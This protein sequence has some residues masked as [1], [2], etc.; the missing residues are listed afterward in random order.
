MRR[1]RG[2]GGRFLNTKKLDQND[3]NPTSEKGSV[4]GVTLSTQSA[5]S[6]GSENPPTNSG[7]NFDS[8]NEQQEEKGVTIQDTHE[9][10]PYF[11]G[12]RNGHGRSS[13]Y[14]ASN[15]SEGGDCFGQPRENMQMNTASHRAL[16]IK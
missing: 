12:N 7:G 11:N 6:S 2:C 10:H 3:A 4:S 5:S 8:S 15:G 13:A 1:A 14:H 16:P 9:E